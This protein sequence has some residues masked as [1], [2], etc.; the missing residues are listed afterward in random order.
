[1][2][3]VSKLGICSAVAAY[4]ILGGSA[5]I[6]G[7]PKVLWEGESTVCRTT[8]KTS[9]GTCSKGQAGSGGAFG[10]VTAGTPGQT[11]L[12][13]ESSVTV[14][15]NTP[16]DGSYDWYNIGTSGVC[17]PNPIRCEYIC[18][19]KIKAAAA[20]AE[21]GH[22]DAIASVA[23]ALEALFSATTPDEIIHAIEQLIEALLG[24]PLGLNY[25][26]G[27]QSDAIVE[28][29]SLYGSES[30]RTEDVPVT[31]SVGGAMLDDFKIFW[32]DEEPLPDEDVEQ[33]VEE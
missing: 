25:D 14:T 18:K 1:M 30:I 26:G 7:A 8:Y 27:L 17:K 12:R 13:G 24:V 21:A 15:W 22:A 3:Q 9:L 19:R 10:C 2:K 5:A 11:N 32:P 23:A 33:P 6:A 31:L 4:L 20:P 29:Q 28:L 16:G